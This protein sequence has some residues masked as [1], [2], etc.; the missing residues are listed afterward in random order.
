MQ[1]LIKKSPKNIPSSF[2]IEP[3]LEVEPSKTKIEPK[4]KI[5]PPKMEEINLKIEEVNP[6]TLEIQAAIKLLSENGYTVKAPSTGKAMKYLTV[7]VKGINYQKLT[8]ALVANGFNIKSDWIEVR[9]GLKNKGE[10]IK[11]GI[12]FEMK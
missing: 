6:K 1:N 5:K 4:V 10:Y 8:T 12:K 3:K 2:K 11:N 7:T 9:K